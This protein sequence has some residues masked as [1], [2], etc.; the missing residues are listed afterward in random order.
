M[1]KLLQGPSMHPG[2][3]IHVSGATHGVG[4]DPTTH[5]FRHRP[6]LAQDVFAGQRLLSFPPPPLLFGVHWRLVLS[7]Q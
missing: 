7:M 6:S 3:G 1:Q 4:D 5:A 2:T